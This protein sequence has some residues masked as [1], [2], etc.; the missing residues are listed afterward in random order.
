MK[1]NFFQKTKIIDPIDPF[2]AIKINNSDIRPTNDPNIF[3]VF[4]W[5][6]GFY[7]E[8]TREQLEADKLLAGKLIGPA[9]KFT[10]VFTG[11]AFFLFKPE[12]TFAADNLR[13]RENDIFEKEEIS[14]YVSPEDISGTSMYPKEISINR[15]PFSKVLIY[16]ESVRYYVF[17]NLQHPFSE[18]TSRLDIPALGT[19]P[20]NIETVSNWNFNRN[21]KNGI[22]IFFDQVTKTA[23]IVKLLNALKQNESADLENEPKVKDEKIENGEEIDFENQEKPTYWTFLYNTFMLVSALSLGVISLQFF[24]KKYREEKENFSSNQDDTDDFIDFQEDQS[25]P[26]F[27]SANALNDFSKTRLRFTAQKIPKS[28]PSTESSKAEEKKNGREEKKNAKDEKKNFALKIMNLF[29]EGMN[30]L[31]ASIQVALRMLNA[32][33]LGKLIYDSVKNFLAWDGELVDGLTIS[34]EIFMDS[35]KHS[36][37]KKYRFY[38]WGRFPE[39]IFSVIR[40][41]KVEALRDILGIT[42]GVTLCFRNF[43]NGISVLGLTSSCFFAASV[44]CHATASVHFLI[45]TPNDFPFDTPFYKKLGIPK[46]FLSQVGYLFRVCGVLFYDLGNK[47]VKKK[48]AMSFQEFQTLKKP[49]VAFVVKE[50]SKSYESVSAKDIEIMTDIVGLTF[51]NISV[52]MQFWNKAN[53]NPGGTPDFYDTLEFG[54]NIPIIKEDNKTTPD[55]L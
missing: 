39:A 28:K 45:Q 51:D 53:Q 20:K 33:D 1:R 21:I 54:G 49:F 24:A 23:L 5:D 35:V 16:F 3:L 15:N 2:V 7:I 43:Q 48:K 17:S 44:L 19:Q 9:A 41:K 6:F 8:T 13:K 32:N 40:S 11:L 22:K 31:I 26:F 46:L 10:F 12:F 47:L 50:M 38:E 18:V 55:E 52:F 25:K 29:Y 42:K 30:L 34:F 4:N 27:P 14:I 36:K 37:P